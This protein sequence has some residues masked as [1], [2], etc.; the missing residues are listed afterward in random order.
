[1]NG[2]P[3]MLSLLIAFVLACSMTGL[4]VAVAALWMQR[5]ILRDQKQLSARALAQG[6]EG[7]QIS[8]D[9]R[10]QTQASVDAAASSTDVLTQLRMEEVNEAK[11]QTALLREVLEAQREILG[12]LR[13]R[14]G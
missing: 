7:L 3:V 4:A 2:S 1:M 13:E 11:A 12:A 5:R 9:I 14:R 10:I 6:E 8:R